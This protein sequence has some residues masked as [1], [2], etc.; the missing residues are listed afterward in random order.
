MAINPILTVEADG[1]GAQIESASADQVTGILAGLYAGLGQDGAISLTPTLAKKQPEVAVALPHAKA[2]PDLARDIVLGGR[3]LREN[4][5]VKPI[6]ADRTLAIQNV[7]GNMF[8]G[9]PGA[10]QQLD[11]LSH[12][13][14][15]SISPAVRSSSARWAAS[16]PAF[17]APRCF[18]MRLAVR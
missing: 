7:F 2:R 4:P 14:R 11:P 18:M 3:L 13:P 15:P 9:S 16:M 10:A 12:T 17:N 1:I 6:K 5:D 8:D